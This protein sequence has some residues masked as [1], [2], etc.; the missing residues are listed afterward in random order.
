MVVVVVLIAFLWHGVIFVRSL[1]TFES[2]HQMPD[3][4]ATEEKNTPYLF[5]F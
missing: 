2:R 1:V 5:A 3:A 4:A